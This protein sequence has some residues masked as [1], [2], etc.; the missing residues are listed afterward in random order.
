MDKLSKALLL[1]R[2]HINTSKIPIVNSA[3]AI[4]KVEENIV[5]EIIKQNNGYKRENYET[6]NSKLATNN[7]S[8]SCKNKGKIIKVN[9]P[10]G[11]N[12]DANF[13]EKEINSFNSNSPKNLT[14][15]HEKLIDLVLMEEDD[16]VEAH[17]IHIDIIMDLAKKEMSILNEVNMP[18]SAIEHYV[19]H[20]DVFLNQKLTTINNLKEKLNKFS[21]HL[22]QEEIVSKKLQGLIKNN[23][24]SKEKYT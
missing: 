19:S 11:L 20:L 3:Q 14:E 13:R 6:S 15:E 7:T 5:Q 16:L 24:T 17:K 4:E 2:Q 1:P 8:G 9:S 10:V 12:P 18:G 23:N 22:K 21:Q